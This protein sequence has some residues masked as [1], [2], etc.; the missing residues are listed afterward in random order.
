MINLFLPRYGDIYTPPLGSDTEGT[1]PPATTLYWY[2]PT[3]SNVSC[4]RWM[5]FREYRAG[6]HVTWTRAAITHTTVSSHNWKQCV[7]HYN[8]KRAS[9]RSEVSKLQTASCETT[10]PKR[11]CKIL[12]GMNPEDRC[13]IRFAVSP[14]L[15]GQSLKTS[16]VDYMLYKLDS[17]QHL[18]IGHHFIYN[19]P[20]KA[21]EQPF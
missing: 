20:Q 14:P 12:T 18:A 4:Y 15:E 7:L 9:S 13:M 19:I 1:K 5:L 11:H 10:Y 17:S 6:C 16:V 3:E 21:L 2:N 8:T